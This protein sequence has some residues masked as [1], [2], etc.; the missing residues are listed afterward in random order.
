MLPIE[1]L[2]PALKETLRLRNS[3]VLVAAPG[4]GKTTRI[5]LALMNEPWL[6]VH[7]RIVMVEPRR[8]ATRS[9]ARYMA[10]ILGQQTGETVG[11]RVKRDSSVSANTQI[12]VITEGILTRMIQNDP[13]LNNIGIVIFDEFHERN[14][15]ADLGLAL[16]L[17]TQSLFREDLRILVMSATLETDP[18]AALLNQAPILRSEGRAFPIETHY[19]KRSMEGRMEQA[20]AKMVFQ[21][22]NEEQGDLMVF[23]PGVGEIRRVEAYLNGFNLAKEI[24]IYPLHGTLSQ[25]AQDRAIAP[26]VMGERKI[27]LTTSIAETSLTVEGVRIV[28]DCGQM[29]I[30]RFSP[31]TGMSHLETVPVSKV[32][33]D[34]RRG[35]AGRLGPG[36]C[37]RLWTE[38]DDHKLPL[39]G[40]PEILEAD[41]APLALELAAWGVSSPQELQWLDFPPKG[42]YQQ[43][44]VLLKQL[45]ALDVET[46][47]TAHGRKM[48]EIGLHPRLA[49][50][51]ISAGELG[52]GELACELAALLN[53]RDIM[54]KDSNATP[55]DLRLRVQAIRL[56]AKEGISLET[57][58]GYSLNKSLCRQVLIEIQHWKKAYGYRMSTHSDDD[59]DRCGILLALAYPDRIAVRKAAGRYLLRSGRGAYLTELQQLSDAEYLVVV[60]LDDKGIENRI[61]LAAELPYADLEKHFKAQFEV[62]T[63]ITWEHEA[64]SVKARKL[65]RFG[66]IVFRDDPLHNPPAEVMAIALLQGIEAEGLEILPWT[67]VSRQ[68]QQRM[69]CISQNDQGWPAV[70]DDALI[71]SL[72][73]WLASHVHGM[74]NQN[75]LQRLHLFDILQNMLSWEQRRELDIFTPTHLVVPSGSHIP[76]DYSEPASPFVAVRLQE[77]FGHAETP[78]IARGRVALTLHL[79]SPAQRPVQVTRDLA[80]FWRNAYFEVKKDLKGRYPKHYWP[81]DPLSALPTNRTRP[82]G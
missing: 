58:Y 80:S 10:S 25:E 63:N 60:E 65:V 31:R 61:F 38:Q 6:S 71:S 56:Y 78:R 23:L 73:G 44:I 30:P 36:V 52:L 17:Q 4:A 49:H 54:L 64:M 33:A 42:A 59:L 40:I 53:E 14:L 35:R 47:I 13:E 3:A 22:V 32:S 70:S 81:D 7:K 27:V 57:A 12:E 76:I 55:I 19:L 24:R 15:H 82:K 39:Q 51:I 79:L 72:E 66:A 45:G 11:Y 26:S 74:R 75:D 48:V 8:L 2:L 34:Q 41:L 28:I 16:C 5:P 77:M 29:R 18:V 43:A 37:Y 62:E 21:A 9:A 20:A 46:R 67:R 50:M 68:L 1:S 69:I